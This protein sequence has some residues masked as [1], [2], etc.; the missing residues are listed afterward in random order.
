MYRIAKGKSATQIA[1]EWDALAPIRFVQIATGVDVTYRRFLV[2]HIIKLTSRFDA[3]RIIDAGC[4][5]GFLTNALTKKF[6]RVLG[7]DPSSESIKIA[8]KHYGDRATYVCGT[9]E[10]YSRKHEN[11]ADVVIA[12][13]VMMDVIKLDAFLDSVHRALSPNGVFVFSITHPCFWPSYYGYKDEPWFAYHKHL[14]IEG[15]FKISAMP[16][17]KRAST[18]VHRPLSSYVAAFQAAKLH[19]EVL[20]EPMPS[21]ALQKCYPKPWM[22][23]R[24]MIGACRKLAVSQTLLTGNSSLRIRK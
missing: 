16:F 13:M 3:E 9:L 7:I 11:I 4:G 1:A 2:P 21:R 8:E 24:Y 19:L 10:S 18:H 15:P 20:L 23:P 17:E 6:P 14:V 5:I 22:Y 12:N